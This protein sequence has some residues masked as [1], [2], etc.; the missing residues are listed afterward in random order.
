MN[1]L[2]EA[3]KEVESTVN[4]LQDKN[5]TFTALEYE[6]KLFELQIK[7]YNLVLIKETRATLNI[8]LNGVI[9]SKDTAEAR[10]KILQSLINKNKGNAT[11][12]DSLKASLNE[13]K[14]E[15]KQYQKRINEY[16]AT[17]P[18]ELELMLITK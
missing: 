10:K 2:T 8:P 6:Q 5:S 18:V 14:E 15:I 3:L 11:I 16:N 7:Q 1:K 4:E 12:C 13:V 9:F 17:T